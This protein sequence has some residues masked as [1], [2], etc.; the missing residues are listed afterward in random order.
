MSVEAKGCEGAWGLS[1]S[2]SYGVKVCTTLINLP[3]KDETLICR[4]CV[5]QNFK[6]RSSTHHSSKKSSLRK[7]IHSG[8]HVTNLSVNVIRK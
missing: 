5:M 3:F 1:L 6:T 4:L 8:G 7:V 2:L